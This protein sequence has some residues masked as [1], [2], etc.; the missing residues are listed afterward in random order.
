MKKLRKKLRKIIRSPYFSVGLGVMLLLCG[1][2]EAVETV[3]ED[4]MEIEVRTHHGLIL[5]GIGQIMKALTDV[6]EGTEGLVVME[7]AE[8][9]EEEIEALESKQYEAIIEGEI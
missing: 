5:Y 6:F 4:F 3:L 8:E 1:V 7:A 9:V 2:L